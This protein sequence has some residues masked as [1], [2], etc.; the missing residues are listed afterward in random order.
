MKRLIYIDDDLD[1]LDLY[2][3][4]LGE[5]FNISTFTNPDDAL[6]VA[7]Q[8][9]FD[10]VLLDIHLPGTTGFDVML[11][12]KSIPHMK[13]AP[14]FF[15]SSE[16]TLNNRLKAFNLGSDDFISRFMDPEEVV[17]RMTKKVEISKDRNI[18]EEANLLTVGDIELDPDNL[19]VK[20][21]GEYMC[22]TQTEYKIIYILL[23][24]YLS[25]PSSTLPKDQLIRFVW[26]LD[27]ESVFPRT[28]STHLTNLRKKL[29]SKKVKIASIRQN[30]FRLKM[31]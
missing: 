15:I 20:C 18:I 30:G 6:K 11:N 7:S 1:A 2:K 31:I 12:I 19:V 26:P 14:L 21:R 29:S 4:I 24:Q 17:A 28:L 5:H 8:Q 27:P 16:N 10:A 3:D 22:L 25:N 9:E 13:K 23:K